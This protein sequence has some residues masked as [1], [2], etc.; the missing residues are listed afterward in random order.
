MFLRRCSIPSNSSTTLSGC[1]KRL[2][3]WRASATKETYVR[4]YIHTDKKTHPTQRRP[5]VPNNT[6]PIPARWWCKGVNDAHR[7][8][9]QIGHCTVHVCTL[10]VYGRLFDSNPTK[11]YSAAIAILQWLDLVRYGPP[12][13]QCSYVQYVTDTVHMYSM[14]LIL[15]ICTVCYWYCAYVQYVTDIVHMYSML[16]ILCICTVCYW[17]CA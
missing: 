2:L 1:I 8:T 16:L 11:H 5:P 15:C 14:L 6:L 3:S 13:P 12:P 7:R 9:I 17:Y 4:T 10:V